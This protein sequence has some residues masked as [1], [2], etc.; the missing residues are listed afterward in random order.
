MTKD[1]NGCADRS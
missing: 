1:R